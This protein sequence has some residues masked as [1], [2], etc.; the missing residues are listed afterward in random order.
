M[1]KTSS[2][3]R[4]ITG[5]R[6]S[7]LP[8]LKPP[9]TL[10]QRWGTMPLH[11]RAAEKTLS[12]QRA[13]ELQPLLQSAKTAQSTGGQEATSPSSTRPTTL[14]SPATEELAPTARNQQSQREIQLAS[15]TS[16]LSVAAETSRSSPATQ[17]TF[18]RQTRDSGEKK[19]TSITLRPLSRQKQEA[20]ITAINSGSTGDFA[21]QERNASTRVP[22]QQQRGAA[23]PQK[24]GT[25]Q[26]AAIHIGTIDVHIVPPTPATLLPTAHSTTAR[27]RSTSALSR[28]FTSVIGLRQG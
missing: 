22:E 10:L 7:T 26:H 17:I 15:A 5:H 1:L 16:K 25:Q 2:Y 9:R 6:D 12:G 8:L 21:E 24:Q 28:E 23:L 3:F 18:E 19:P 13:S 4:H 14:H 11:D 27:A 20:P